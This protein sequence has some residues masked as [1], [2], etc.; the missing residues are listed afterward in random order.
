VQKE[1]DIGTRDDSVA[2]YKKI[3][4]LNLRLPPPH[5][6][7]CSRRQLLYLFVILKALAGST[8]SR[9]VMLS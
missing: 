4:I 3:E 8:S 1:P 2:S 6:L 7:W 5:A 9:P